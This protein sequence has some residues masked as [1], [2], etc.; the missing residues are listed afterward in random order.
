MEYFETF[1]KGK[2]QYFAPNRFIWWLSASLFFRKTSMTSSNSAYET[3]FFYRKWWNILRNSVRENFNIS[4]Q[5]R[6]IWWLSVS[7]YGRKT[8]MTSS[9]SAYGTI[10]F[11]RKWWNILRHSVSENLNISL[12]KSFH[13]MTLS[14]SL[15]SKD[16]YDLLKLSIWND[17]FL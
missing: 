11:Y 2:F 10:F 15:W 14:K 13:M 4:L 7:L 1:C 9:N 6:F 17:I 12:Q 3:I 5:N 16:E 8:S